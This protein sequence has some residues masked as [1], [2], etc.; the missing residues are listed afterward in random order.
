MEER[1][2]EAGC[3]IAYTAYAVAAPPR[4]TKRSSKSA[5][6][7]EEGFRVLGLVLPGPC[8]VKRTFPEVSRLFGDR[9]ARP[10]H[11]VEPLLSPAG[12]SGKTG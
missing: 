3:L 1:L 5:P 10:V 12:Q 9:N 6:A 11:G 2:P 4:L 7:M 8:L